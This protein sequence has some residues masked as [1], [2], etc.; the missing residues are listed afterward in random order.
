MAPPRRPPR[1][2]RPPPRARPPRDRMG[3]GVYL[4]DPASQPAGAVIGWDADFVA[5]RDAFP[6]ATVHALVLPRHPALAL[7]HPLDG[8]PVPSAADPPSPSPSPSPALPPG[9]DWA[10]DVVCGVH[11]APSMRHLHV[12]VLS[13][14]MHSPALRHRKHYN[15]FV[16][17]F[18]V[19][20]ADFPLADDDPRHRPGPMG[21]LR[22]QLWQPVPPLQGAPR[23]RVR[24][25]EAALRPALA[26]RKRREDTRGSR[27]CERA[28]LD[29][30]VYSASYRRPLGPLPKPIH[31]ALPLA[32][33]VDTSTMQPPTR[34]RRLAPRRHARARRRETSRQSDGHHAAGGSSRRFTQAVPTPATSISQTS[35]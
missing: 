18:F 19:D 34:T 10:A 29:S 14:D 27:S 22:R 21:Y 16:T 11:A 23:R 3:L 2:H 6:K 35:S 24:R 4:G 1:D 5:V 20:L 33:H 8:R 13:R 26:R 9:R 30:V 7:R 15:S 28:G 32:R 31:P 17:P 12:Q 25:V